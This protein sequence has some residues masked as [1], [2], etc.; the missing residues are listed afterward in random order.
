MTAI[1]THHM[2]SIN[3]SFSR[4]RLDLHLKKETPQV[5]VR[6]MT[7]SRSMIISHLSV[8]FPLPMV[9]YGFINPQSSYYFGFNGEVFAGG[10]HS[11]CWLRPSCLC[12]KIL[13]L[14]SRT[15]TPATSRLLLAIWNPRATCFLREH[16]SK[17]KLTLSWTD[18]QGNILSRRYVFVKVF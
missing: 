16:R 3:V 17:Q 4:L 8:H 10:F 15:L 18:Y 14:D 2:V 6:T 11:S 5:P 12:H 1:F 13:S 9:T 7:L